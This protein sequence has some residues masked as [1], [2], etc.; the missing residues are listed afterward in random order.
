MADKKTVATPRFYDIFVKPIIS[1]KAAK[2]AEANGMAFEVSIDATKKE[3]ALAI[4]TLY[5]VKVKKVN[6]V[7]T[8]GKTKTFK[9]R[10]GTR[11]TVKKAYITL[12]DNQ[13]ID[14][15]AKM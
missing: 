9:G 5:K 8:A 14:V 3:I 13:K 11:K 7:R 4:E 15:M 10:E 6:I 1:E 2:L 12:A